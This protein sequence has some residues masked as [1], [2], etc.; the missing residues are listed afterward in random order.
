M[1]GI[2]FDSGPDRSRQKAIIA[3][4]RK[5]IRRKA[6]AAAVAKGKE[7]KRRGFMEDSKDK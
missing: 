3:R 7:V 1:F 2:K 4:M 5:S 6:A